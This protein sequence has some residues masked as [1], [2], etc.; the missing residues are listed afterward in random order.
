[1]EAR[2]T[3]TGGKDGEDGKDGKDEVP[4]E[5]FHW[6]RMAEWHENF[7]MVLPDV[8]LTAGSAFTQVPICQC[9]CICIARTGASSNNGPRETSILR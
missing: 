8:L 4:K 3:G 2:P 1:M 9:R 5:K 6:I 7:E